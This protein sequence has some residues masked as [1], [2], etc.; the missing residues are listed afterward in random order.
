MLQCTV[1]LCKV[2]TLGIFYIMFLHCVA[3]V[4][5]LKVFSY[6]ILNLQLLK[7]ATNICCI[8]F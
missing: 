4:N 3:Q 5:S 7:W 1:E 2:P 6:S 8:L